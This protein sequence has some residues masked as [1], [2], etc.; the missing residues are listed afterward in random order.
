[1]RAVVLFNPKAGSAGGADGFCAAV[2]DHPDLTLV[3]PETAE[4]LDAAVRQAAEEG[5]DVVASAGGDGTLHAV[6]NALARLPVRAEELP[7]LAVIPFG[8]GN[9][10]ARTLAI[11]TDPDAA[12]DLLH[13][14]ERRPIDLIRVNPDDGPALYAINAC[15]GGFSGQVEEV[16]TDDLKKTWGPLAYLIG[17]IKVIPDLTE[18]DTRLAYDGGP[19]EPEDAFNVVVGNGRMAGGGKPIAPKANPED[20][21]LDVVVIRRCS[22]PQMAALAAL[23]FAGDYLQ[24]DLVVHRRVQQLRV[25]SK[26]GMWFNVDGEL[27]TNAPITF[28]AVPQ[29]LRVV[30]GPEY[31]AAVDD[32]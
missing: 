28:E 11:P 30:V 26:P 31:A 3:Q 13:A 21:L 8:T 12:L 27:L 23:A 22:G 2:E 9:D 7:A 25:A 32:A 1:M 29:A 17:G 16:L 18:Y 4:G 6:A 20:G 24:S 14:G 19:D 15:T 5:A 10:F